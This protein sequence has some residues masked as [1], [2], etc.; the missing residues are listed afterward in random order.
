[1]C[2]KLVSG[3]NKIS[4]STCTNRNIVGHGKVLQIC[5]TVHR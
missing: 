1:M 2:K 3:K 4:E 5:Y